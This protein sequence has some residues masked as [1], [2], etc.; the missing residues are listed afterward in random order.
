[1]KNN[2][3]LILHPATMYFLLTV[4]IILL[5]WIMDIYGIGLIVPLTGEELRIQSLISP[6]GIRWLL[7]NIVT[8]FTD[9]PPLGMVIVAMFG[10][11]IAQHSGFLNICI[12]SAIGNSHQKKIIILL[13]IILGLISNIIGDAGYIVL[14][15]IAASLFHNVNLNPIAGIITSYVSVACGYS[16][17][18]ILSTMDP[19]LAKITD[20]AV[21]ANGMG[22]GMIGPFSNYIFMFVSTVVIAMIIYF[23]V[24]KILI[25]QTN[26]L[27]MTEIQTNQVITKKEK[28][29]LYTALIIGAIYF[30]IILLSTF[31][32]Y[33]I[34]RGV[35][36]NLMRSP[37]I[38]GVLFLISFGLGLMGM[39]YGL[40]IGKYKS[41]TDVVEG[42]T[43]PMKLL[44]IY[45]VIVFFASQMFACISYT[46]IDKYL[47][48]L[49]S[50]YFSSFS[51]G[52]LPMLLL[53]I[54]FSALINLLMVSAV[55][56]WNLVSYIVISTFTVMG[57]SP[58]IVQC[59]FR[60]GDSSTNAI[61]PFLFYMPL[62]FA[63]IQ[64]YEKKSSYLFLLKYTWRFSIYILIGWSLLFFL[65]YIT[66]LPIGI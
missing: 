13:V 7:R 49:G 2:T 56:K 58:D 5:S 25:P 42:L 28:R 34:L 40:N 27:R 60:I 26:K 64:L 62:V 53:L 1:M 29:S 59:A 39:V 14:L 3:K 45:L 16:A 37:F 9:F 38:M 10:I 65:W 66:R 18:V 32:S 30:L 20:E 22:N 31:S 52:E 44:G 19:M 33:G 17:N 21:V 61:T 6:E 12:R 15:P 8:N 55:S 57:T 35:S 41:D 36:G 48:I 43:Q 4:F 63:Y 47:V 51:L 46:N 23:V 24:L 54:L 11:G 50:I